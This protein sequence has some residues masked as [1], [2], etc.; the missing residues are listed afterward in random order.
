[1]K[2]LLGTVRRPDVIFRSNGRFDIAARVVRDL[3]I[4]PGDVVDILYES[5]RE[6]YLYVARHF[7]TAP[8]GRF[9]AQVFP[10]NR[11]RGGGQHFRGSSTR[12]CRSILAICGWQEKAALP[13]GHVVTDSSGRRLLPIIVRFNIKNND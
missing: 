2:S 6:Y 9:E 10:S 13:C 5:D 11:R 7:T 4:S 8:C 1:M 3:D 12:L